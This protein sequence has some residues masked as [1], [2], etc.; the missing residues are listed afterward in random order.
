MAGD[1]ISAATDYYYQNPVTNGTGNNLT[2]SIV[3]S[4][5]QSILGSPA[6]GLAKGNAT[7]ISNNLNADAGFISKTAPDAGN[8]N[9]NCNR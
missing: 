3:T 7:P 8:P 6:T 4:L 5:I 9:G 2:A 1:Q